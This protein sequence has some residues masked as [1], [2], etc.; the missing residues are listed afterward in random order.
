MTSIDDEVIKD[1]MTILH[2]EL[3]ITLVVLFGS[4]VTG[5]AHEFSDYDLLIVAKGLDD[6]PIENYVKLC[7]IL[8]PKIQPLGI[9]PSGLQKAISELK[10]LFFDALETG[11]ILY[12][13]KEFTETLKQIICDVKEKYTIKKIEDGWSFDVQA[14]IA[15]GL[16]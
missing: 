14:V 15:A 13:K 1:A 11:I 3:D 6:N 4:R 2:N 7:R 5:K 16:M 12:Q 8:N 10:F 9:S